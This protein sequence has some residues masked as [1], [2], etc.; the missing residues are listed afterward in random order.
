MASIKWKKEV[1]D[2]GYKC[3]RCGKLV[4]DKE[5]RVLVGTFE[6]RDIFNTGT[7]VCCGRCGE[8][9]GIIVYD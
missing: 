5:K 3:S 8:S 2:Y 9:V 4:F 1:Y 7:M 6:Q